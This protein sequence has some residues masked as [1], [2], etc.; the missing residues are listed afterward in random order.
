MQAT[1]IYQ[2]GSSYSSATSASWYGKDAVIAECTV[3][4]EGNS[5]DARK[6]FGLGEQMIGSAAY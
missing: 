1:N 2:R 5:Y 4:T 6:A 3:T